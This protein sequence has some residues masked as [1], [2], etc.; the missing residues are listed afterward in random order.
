MFC[1]QFWQARGE[2]EV[3]VSIGKGLGQKGPVAADCCSL[4]PGEMPEGHERTQ[5][6]WWLHFRYSQRC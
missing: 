2:A 5:A 6:V 3:S 4:S 1:S